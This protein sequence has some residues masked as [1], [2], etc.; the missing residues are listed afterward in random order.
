MVSFDAFLGICDF[1]ANIRHDLREAIVWRNY[2]LRV[3][4]HRVIDAK[5]LLL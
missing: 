4:L 1:L 3:I 5:H 2:H